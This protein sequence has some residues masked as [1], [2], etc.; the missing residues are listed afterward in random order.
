MIAQARVDFEAL[1]LVL[2]QFAAKKSL[3]T[4]R[5]VI[6]RVIITLSSVLTR[7]KFSVKHFH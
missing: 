6:G 4:E 2:I 5:D 3:S 1:C 7:G